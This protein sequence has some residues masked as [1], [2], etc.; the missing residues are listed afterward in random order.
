[1]LY[2]Q[3]PVVRENL[4][5]TDSIGFLTSRNPCFRNENADLGGY[6]T[7][8]QS[9]GFRVVPSGGMTGSSASSDVRYELRTQARGCRVDPHTMN[10]LG[11]RWASG[12]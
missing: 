8:S 6:R 1:M 9:G 2:S 12:E 3:L 11:R 4:V 7:I 10:G 5:L